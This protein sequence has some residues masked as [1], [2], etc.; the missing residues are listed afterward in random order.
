MTINEDENSAPGEPLPLNQ[1]QIH[2]HEPN[3][4]QNNSTLDQIVPLL[5][6]IQQQSMEIP[7]L[8]VNARIQ[9]ED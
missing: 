8:F 1:S 3:N 6:N 2:I 7:K 4:H 9:T 5:S